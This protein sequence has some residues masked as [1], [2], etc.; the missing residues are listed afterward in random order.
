MW[1]N[2]N[3]EITSITLRKMH[4]AKMRTHVH[5]LS[6]QIILTVLSVCLSVPV[7]AS[8]RNRFCAGTV[9]YVH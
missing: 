3:N 1:V 2:M 8:V 6:P 5:F 9:I 7:F 4:D